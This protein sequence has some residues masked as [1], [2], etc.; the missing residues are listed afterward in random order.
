MIVLRRFLFFL[1]AAALSAVTMLCLW[2]DV[3]VFKDGVNEISCTEI[4]QELTL[5]VIVFLHA[6]LAKKHPE[7]RYCNM[8]IAGLFLA[9]L[10]RELDALFDLLAHG[11][12]VWLALFSTLCTVVLP[13]R[14]FRHTL[15]QLEQYSRTPWYG[16]I[17]SGLLTILVFSRLFGMHQLWQTILADGYAR[18]VKNIVEEGSE[19]FGYLLC[20]TATIGYCW[21]FP[22][23]IDKYSHDAHPVS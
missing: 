5:A 22:R 4:T 3:G 11:S 13:L 12:W 15:C 21:R 9:M 6:R 8:L 19:L 1:A 2:I 16:M 18:V 23:A 14:H 7:L 20:L 17:M 10:I